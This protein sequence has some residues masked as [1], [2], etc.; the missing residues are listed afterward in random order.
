MRRLEAG[1]TRKQTHLTTALVV[2]MN[3]GS[4]PDL[5]DQFLGSLFRQTELPDIVAFGSSAVYVGL[6]LGSSFDTS[7]PV[8]SNDL[9]YD[10]LYS[11]VARLARLGGRKRGEAIRSGDTRPRP[12]R[13]RGRGAPPRAAPRP[14]PCDT[15]ACM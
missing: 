10:D 3:M 14:R 15:T 12:G 9:A 13:R 7:H 8:W 6:N 5:I 1:R 4:L 2:P 11:C